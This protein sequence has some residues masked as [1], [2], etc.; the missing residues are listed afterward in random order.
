MG[1]V[2]V[3]NAITKCRRP[4]ISSIPTPYPPV[5]SCTPSV[6]FRSFRL[7]YIP[8]LQFPVHLFPNLSQ[9]YIYQYN[10]PQIHLCTNSP[11]TQVKNTLKFK[12]VTI[13]KHMKPSVKKKGGKNS[14][15]SWALGGTVS[16]TTEHIVKNTLFH[17]KLHISQK[18]GQNLVS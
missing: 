10:E 12:R 1:H 16:K 8:H 3:E 6:P 11:E 4:R 7:F 17:K 18:M 5:P 15:T 9:P 14:F 13:E 2:Y